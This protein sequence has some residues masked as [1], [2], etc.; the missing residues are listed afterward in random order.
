MPGSTARYKR[1][2]PRHLFGGFNAE[3]VHAA[4][5]DN[6]LSAFCDAV[7][8]LDYVPVPLNHEVDAHLRRALFARFREKD[9]IP[10]ERHAQRAQRLQGV[11][12]RYGAFPYGLKVLELRKKRYEERNGS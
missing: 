11:L 5:A 2:A 8:S 12:A 6:A 10:V 7:F 1:N 9:H 3:G 4:V